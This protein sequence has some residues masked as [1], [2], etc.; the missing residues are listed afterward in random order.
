MNVERISKHNYYLNIATEVSKRGTCLRR[1][2]GAVIV[3]QDQIVS[4]GYTGAPRGSKN[5]VDIGYCVRSNMDVPA[6]E[7]YE[8]CRSV[9]AEMNALIHASRRDTIGG[10]MYFMGMD[11]QDGR[12]LP[13]E[14]EPCRLC[15]RVIINAGLEKVITSQGNRDVI[16]Y[17]VRDWITHEDLDYGIESSVSGV[18]NNHC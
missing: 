4:T 16:T 13:D 7:R 3:N 1:N 8:L 2:Y 14:A 15:K 18:S 17:Q 11:A 5:C 6:G 12:P 9:H 10:L